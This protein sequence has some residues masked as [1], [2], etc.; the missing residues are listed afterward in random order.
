MKS[1]IV[2]NGTSDVD[3]TQLLNHIHNAG[4]VIYQ[5]HQNGGGIIVH[6][7]TEGFKLAQGCSQDNKL[8]VAVNSQGILSRADAKWGVLKSPTSNDKNERRSLL[9]RDIIMDVEQLPER[10]GRRCWAGDS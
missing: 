7:E 1:N 9:K 10:Y 5:K 4:N 2:I 8:S 6:S 3:L